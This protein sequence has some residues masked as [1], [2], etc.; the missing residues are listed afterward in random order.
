MHMNILSI[1]R[2]PLTGYR[3]ESYKNGKLVVL[4]PGRHLLDPTH[5]FV[6]SVSMDLDEVDLGPKKIVTIKNGSSFLNLFPHSNS[7][8]T[9]VQH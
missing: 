3:G 7:N 6:K 5:T 1:T 9:L 2:S 4:Y 8:L